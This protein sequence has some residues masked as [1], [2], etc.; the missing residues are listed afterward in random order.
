M[1][2]RKWQLCSFPNQTIYFHIF[3]SGQQVSFQLL[4]Q[5]ISIV[6]FKYLILFLLYIC[7]GTGKTRTLVAAIEKIIRSTENSI[8][9]C[10]NS[11]AACDEITRRLMKVCGSKEMFRLSAKSHNPLPVS[12][13]IKKYSNFMKSGIHIP[14]L[15]FLYSFRILICT[16]Q[17]SGYLSRALGESGFN[18]SH[19][20][21]IIID[22]CA[23]VN[24]TAALI[25]IAG[26]SYFFLIDMI[27]L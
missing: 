7:K 10:A 4:K 16:L 3:C 21:H 5:S 6:Y 26:N 27:W 2:S 14:C 23:C 22:E 20:S 13:E 15:E 19:F 24:E 11:N 17:T 1:T 18:P 8:L 25:P 9:V 12:D